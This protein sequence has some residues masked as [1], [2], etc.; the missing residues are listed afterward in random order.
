MQS[1]KDILDAIGRITL[2]METRYPE[3][4]RFL[5]ESPETLPTQAHPH[6]DSRALSDYLKGLNRLLQEYQKT[7]LA[8]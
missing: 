3:L 7:H 1:K 6:M 8:S 5:D 2:E 4:Y